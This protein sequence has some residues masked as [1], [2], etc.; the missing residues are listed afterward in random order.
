MIKK[1]NINRSIEYNVNLSHCAAIYLSIS[2]LLTHV[3]P[4]GAVSHKLVI[5]YTDCVI[6][7]TILILNELKAQCIFSNSNEYI[8][9]IAGT[10]ATQYFQGK[11]WKI[12]PE[13]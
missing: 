13:W 12:H 9:V 5:F 3:A 10:N 7:V 8:Y 4:L 11:N 1:I 6:F 2:V